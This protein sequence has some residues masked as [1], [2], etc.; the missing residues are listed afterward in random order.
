MRWQRAAAIDLRCAD[1]NDRAAA[2][3]RLY[4]Q[5]MSTPETTFPRLKP[6]L[7]LIVF[8]VGVG[9]LGVEIAA[10]RL[11]APY[12]GASEVVW[13]N[14]I[15]VVLVALAIGYWWGGKL[16]DRHPRMSALCTSV[17][18]AASLTALLP[19]VSRPLLNTG[20]D[21]LD[22][23]NAGAFVGSLLA[24]LVLLA[25]PVLVMG[26]ITPWA[27]RIGIERVDKLEAGALAGRLSAIGTGGSLLGTLLSALVLIPAI[28]TKRT[29]LFFSFLMAVVAVTGLPRKWRL[30]A[31]VVPLVIVVLFA[32]PPGG[33]KGKATNGKVI[34]EAETSSQYARVIERANGTRV[35]ELNEGQARHS[36]YKPNSVLVDDY[37]DS[38]LVLPLVADGEPPENIAI[39]GN[40]A[41][42]VARGY[43]YFFPETKVDGV[44]IDGE[45]TE[46]G[47]RYFGLGDRNFRAFTADA[48]PYLRE[49]DVKYDAILMD[50]YRQPYI[51]FYL[52]T[53]E[54]FELTAERLN[55]GGT[56]LVNVGHPEGSKLL[57]SVLAATIATSYPYVYRDH[58]RPTNTVLVASD[59]PL[60]AKN[61]VAG[62][63]ELPELLPT[64]L[65]EAARFEPANTSGEVYTDDKAPVEW[66]IDR[67]IVQYAA[68]K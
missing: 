59:R 43:A 46:V 18:L 44:E 51:P 32:L 11:L 48:R 28:G 42:S 6:P 20:V 58:T 60:E 16:G 41:G 38:P 27:L 34:F 67:S 47:R 61:I 56:L 54:F 49:T 39:L 19:F 25:I 62:A 50:A 1:P 31:T 55:P 29:F 30:R 8:I 15:G 14:T 53:R 7:E 40:A 9:T 63:A 64:A 36:V 23:I 13:A 3:R 4:P 35:L 33:I 17:L 65:R 68:G 2:A 66:L 5:E 52:T 37:W 24:T 12:F 45:L 22:S 10:V 21:A 57:E 26:T